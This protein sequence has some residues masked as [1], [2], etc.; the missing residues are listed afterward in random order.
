MSAIDWTAEPDEWVRSLLDSAP[1]LSDQQRA[2]LA[3]LLKPVRV[4]RGIA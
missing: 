1:P 4:E 2:A 3:E